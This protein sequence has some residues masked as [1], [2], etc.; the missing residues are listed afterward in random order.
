MRKAV[1]YSVALLSFL[2]LLLSFASYKLF[3]IPLT[4]SEG[5]RAGVV[6]KISKQG[7]IIKTWEG[8]LNVGIVGE[9]LSGP[10]TMKIWQFS[11]KGDETARKIEGYARS[12]ERITLHY[13]QPYVM[14]ALYGKSEYLVIDVYARAPK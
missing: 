13:K 6:Y 10:V 14:G 9:D 3:G 2:L 11:V 4:Y 1:S 8:D 12:G 5:E 7:Y